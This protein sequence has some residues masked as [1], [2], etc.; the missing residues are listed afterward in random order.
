MRTAIF[1][2]AYMIGQA[3]R[4]DFDNGWGWM[5]SIFALSMVYM[6]IQEFRERRK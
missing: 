6:D 4:P 2:G 1:F 3:I 5:I